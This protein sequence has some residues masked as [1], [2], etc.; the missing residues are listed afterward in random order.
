M[1][2]EAFSI[3]SS[4]ALVFPIAE[5][6]AEETRRRPISSSSSSTA[7]RCFPFLLLSLVNQSPPHLRGGS[8]CHC[9]VTLRPGRPLLSSVCRGGTRRPHGRGG[10]H[11]FSSFFPWRER[12][13][14][15]ESEKKV[16]NSTFF[17]SGAKKREALLRSFLS[18][19]S[20]SF[21]RGLSRSVIPCL[22]F[23][24]S[25]TH[26]QSK[27]YE[28]AATPNQTRRTNVSFLLQS[29]MLLSLSPF[30]LATP[31]A[32][33]VLNRISTLTN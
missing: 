13:R 19:N 26:T 22:S 24:L 6:E 29:A 21:A 32:A 8:G 7:F 4:G 20:L 23:C 31:I 14:E 16:E 1:N 33:P 28:E 25:L 5:Q 17:P 30:G 18:S 9:N 12:K 3:F 15:R 10:G 11:N 2:R 27:W